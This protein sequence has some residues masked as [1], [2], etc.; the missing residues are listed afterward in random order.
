MTEETKYSKI[1]NP[2]FL[3]TPKSTEI[4][5]KSMGLVDRFYQ[6][7]EAIK[8]LDDYFERFIKSPEETDQKPKNLT[9]WFELMNYDIT[10]LENTELEKIRKAFQ[11]YKKDVFERR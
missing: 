6:D 9:E 3:G 11:E 7:H 1:H 10:R 2:I 5:L 4:I 8:F